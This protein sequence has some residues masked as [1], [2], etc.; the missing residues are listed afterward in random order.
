MTNILAQ[1]ARVGLL[2]GA[3]MP[4]LAMAQTPAA[5]QT[6]EVV[7][8]ARVDDIVVTAQRRSER[9]RDVPISITAI[10][11]E[12]LIQ[13]GVNSTTDLQRVTPGVQLA[14]YGGYLQPSIR[15]ISSAGAG[16]GDSSNVAIY[17]DGVYQPNQSGQLIDLPDIQQ[18]EVLKGP[19]GTL[20]GQNATGGAII[21]T[22]VAPSFETTGRVSASYG[23][24]N[25]ISIRGY[26][27]VPLSEDKVALSV[28]GA[29]RDRGGYRRDIVRGGHDTGLN[30]KLVRA[31]LLLKPSDTVSLTLGAYYSNRKD[32]GIY[33]GQPLE[34]TAGTPLGYA[35]ADAYGLTVPKPSNPKEFATNVRPF[36]HL[37]TYGAN[38]LGKFETDFGTFNTVTS[39]AKVKV[40]NIADVDYTAVNLGVVNTRQNNRNFIQEL[41]FSSEKTNGFSFSAGLFYMDSKENYAPNSFGLYFLAFG[42]P[43]GI[44]PNT[45]TLQFAITQRAFNSKHSYAA[46]GEAS[47]EFN[48]QLTLSIGGR[49]AYETQQT[50]DNHSSMLGGN[51]PLIPDPRGKVKFKRFTPKATL[52]YALNDN[53]NIYASYSQGFKS[54]YVNSGDNHLLVPPIKPVQPEKV[55]AY[56]VGYKGRLADGVNLNVAAFWYNYKDLQVYT[57][58]P[59]AIPPQPREIYQNAASARIKGID[60]DVSIR[61]TP[62]LTFT[63][64]GAYL[65]AKYR[66][67]PSASN[68]A[69]NPG[70]FGFDAISTNATGNRLIRTPK[71]SG[72]ASLNYQVET[73]SGRFGAY[74]ASTYNSGVYYNTANTVKQKRYALLDGELSYSPSGVEGL[75]LVLWGKNL[76]DKEYLT[77]ALTLGYVLAGSYADPRTYGV[78]AEFAF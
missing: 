16:L 48:D 44:Y 59:G 56:E 25:D 75:R 39:L 57:Y 58:N 27:S 65:D 24:Y 61:V 26:A 22:S 30:S 41:N 3:A 10:N 2:C 40:H 47:Y 52:R 74:V 6:S 9:L 14:F 42:D 68:F 7:E 20:Y 72:N 21:I 53:S 73:G 63:A 32:G 15:G 8:H 45:G 66:S 55:F 11:E 64:G 35:L 76:T 78:R 70:G 54:G 29:Y 50:A 4:A 18:I 36:V 31:R 77:S 49:Y 37:K 28:A 51:G 13:A 43:L 38:L 67:F 69:P 1:F 60:A 46:Y 71:F 23:N 5:P 19:Q 33:A 17:V 12:T 62:E 34:G